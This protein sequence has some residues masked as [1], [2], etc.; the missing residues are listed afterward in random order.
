V[1][2]SA[3]LILGSLATNLKRPA[4]QPPPDS[5]D[6]AARLRILDFFDES[7]EWRAYE[8]NSGSFPLQVAADGSFTLEDVP[9]GPY[10]LSVTIGDSAYTGRDMLKRVMRRSTASAKEDVVVPDELIGSLPVDLG[11]FSV[12]SSLSVHN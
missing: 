1:D 2:W 4:I 6:L 9:P 3:Q 5:P 8:R 7:E 10:Q 12:Q 11:T